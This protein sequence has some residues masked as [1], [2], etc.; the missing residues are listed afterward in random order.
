MRHTTAATDII[1]PFEALT[2]LSM[3]FLIETIFLLAIIRKV[4]FDQPEFEFPSDT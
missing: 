3:K 1:E 4:N 2:E